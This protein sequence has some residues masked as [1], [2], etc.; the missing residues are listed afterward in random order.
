M[1]GSRHPKREFP[2]RG[3]EICESLPS[4][5]NCGHDPRTTATVKDSK[6]DEGL[7]IGRV[8]DEVVAL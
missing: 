6:H 4:T 2:W 8:G 3:S 5:K 7:F 1:P